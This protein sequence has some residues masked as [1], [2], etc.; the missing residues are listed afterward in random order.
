MFIIS[1]HWG[2]NNEIPDI[3]LNSTELACKILHGHLI[4]HSLYEKNLKKE[5]QD[6]LKMYLIFFVCYGTIVMFSD[7]DQIGNGGSIT[8]E[9]SQ[10]KCCIAKQKIPHT[11]DTNSLERCG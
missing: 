6:A 3:I 9:S 10:T 7:N 1:F 5:L 11:G 8:M 2:I 4:K